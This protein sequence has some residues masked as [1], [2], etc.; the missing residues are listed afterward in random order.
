MVDTVVHAEIIGEHPDELRAFYSALFGWDAPPGDPV[1][2]EV[3]DPESYSFNPSP[4]GDGVPVGIGGGSGFAPRV[5]F[6]VGVD[7]VAATLGRAVA[8]GA[9][10]VVA[11]TTRPDGGVRVAQFADPEGNIIGLAGPA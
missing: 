2:S 7:D 6:Y 8:L 11:V 9:T 1:A 10:I 3:S 5:V 4:G